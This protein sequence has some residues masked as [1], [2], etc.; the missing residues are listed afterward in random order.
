M[1]VVEYARNVVGLA[2]ANSAENDPDT[3]NAVIDIQM[4]QRQIIEESRFGG[5][6]RLG[7]YVAALRRES[8]VLDL[9]ERTGRLEEDAWRIEGLRKNPSEAFRL[10]VILD[11]ERGVIERH[12]HRYEVSPKY[13]DL[14]EEFG[15]VFS[16]YHRRE[17]GAKLMEFI[18]L[19]GHPFFLATQAICAPGKLKPNIRIRSRQGISLIANTIL[20]YF[21]HFL[22]PD[23]NNSSSV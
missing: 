18:E 20:I 14:F 6:M 22:G 2:D 9:Y 16:G 10:G 8:V 1:A 4:S 15:L 7:G 21:N 17:D 23:F 5:T 19:P 13:V 11:S 12:R 3:A